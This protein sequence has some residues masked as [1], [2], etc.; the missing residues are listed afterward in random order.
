MSR[1]FVMITAAALMALTA[2]SSPTPK[3]DP[4]PEKLLYVALGDSYTAG[5]GIQP[6]DQN[7]VA[8]GRSRA[9]YPATV[10]AHL[11]ANLVDASCSGAT[12]ESILGSAAASPGTA[13]AQLDSVSKQAD[14]VTIGIGANNEQYAG[15]LFTECPG[16]ATTSAPC[17]AFH[18]DL[19]AMLPRTRSSVEQVI[20]AVKK[21]AP[22]ARVFLVGYIR[23][24][25]DDGK[26]AIPGVNQ[27]AVKRLAEAEK[28]FAAMM[29]Q[30][31]TATDVE[32]IDARL[33]SKG[34]D[35]CSAAPW[36]NI[37]NSG[38]G[39]IMHPNRAGMDG[40]AD[41]LLDAIN[42]GR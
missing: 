8:C 1:K 31:A 11:R 41:M 3:K 15:R 34:H 35:V 10:A 9:N 39:M 2:C 24:S 7:A 21:Q 6:F 22:N 26:C 23:F 16:T 12:T 19:D 5:P 17:N 18:R 30:A 25:P 40:V 20:E 37:A 42:E 32:F 38:D 14:I 4:E 33:Q 27:P 29:N 13:T 36:V 28:R